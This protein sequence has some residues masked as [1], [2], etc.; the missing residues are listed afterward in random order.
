MWRMTTERLVLLSKYTG[1]HQ[2]GET[3]LMESSLKFLARRARL[4]IDMERI[5]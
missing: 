4:N 2:L 3:I 1:V 5:I